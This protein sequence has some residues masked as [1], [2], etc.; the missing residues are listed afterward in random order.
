AAGLDGLRPAQTPRDM[1]S[2]TVGW[3]SGEAS[4]STT[5]RYIAA[6]FDDDQN[7]N[8]LRPATTL[9]AVATLPL[10]R[11]LTIE[12]RGENLFDARVEAGISGASIVELASPRTLWIGFRY[13][14]R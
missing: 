11:A 8:R 12:A 1:V 6:Q 5:L 7:R 2:G 3:R 9:D 10:S 4:L 14:M 13:R